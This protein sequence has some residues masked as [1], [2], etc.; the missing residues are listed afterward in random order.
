MR[1]V[2][3][4]PLIELYEILGKQWLRTHQ[5]DESFEGSI[6]RHLKQ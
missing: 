2:A 3:S 5:V 1:G 4:H 6:A